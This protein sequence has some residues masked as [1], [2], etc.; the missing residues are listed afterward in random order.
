MKKKI[1]Q[2]ES[3]RCEDCDRQIPSHRTVHYGDT[4]LCDRC[5]FNRF[6]RETGGQQYPE[7]E[8]VIVKDFRGRPHEFHFTCW[9][10]PT[11]IIIDA[12]EMK[13]GRPDG[14]KFGIMGDHD[15]DVMQLFSQ[16]YARIRK[17][18]S[19]QHL[20][21]DRRFGRS[22]KDLTVRGRVQWDDNMDGELPCLIIDGQEVSWRQ[23][24][25][26]L[27]SFEGWHFKLEIFD[28]TE[29]VP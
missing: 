1:D 9:L 28:R 5:M 27:M 17:G 20:K 26:M 15:A 8:P 16:L 11:G 3:T 12:L 22:I 24:G 19:H 29:E 18:L 6:A 25:R 10:A 21:H 13:R 2:I 14:Y 4:I 23:F 7:F